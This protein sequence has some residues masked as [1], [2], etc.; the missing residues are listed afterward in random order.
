MGLNLISVPMANGVTSFPLGSG[1]IGQLEITLAASNGAPSAGT[2][3][4]EALN[5][6]GNYDVIENAS[7]INLTA[8]A[9]GPILRS[10]FGHWQALRLTLSG[11]TGGVGNLYGAATPQIAMMPDYAF[12]GFRALCTQSYTEANVKNGVQFETSLLVPTIA[13]GAVVGTLFTTGAKPVII[14]DRQVATTCTQ[15]ELHVYS[16]PT[17]TAGTTVP[18]FNLNNIPGNAST[19]T[20]IV[21][22]AATITANGTEI[23]APTYV[24]GTTGNGQTLFGT[25]A[26]TGAERILA[27]NTTYLLTFKNT[28]TVIGAAAVYTTWYEGQPDLPRA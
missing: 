8:L 3:K 2:L 19:S 6:A 23:A 28:G 22:Q 13:I 7:A 21:A 25:Y 9:T 11:V 10:D 24:V 16:G 20:V 4:I 17:A 12:T 15:S 26:A 1:T 27:P 5:W 14:K 18:T